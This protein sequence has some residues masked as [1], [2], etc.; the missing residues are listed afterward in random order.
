MCDPEYAHR[1]RW[2]ALFVLCLTLAILGI[3]TS[4]VNVAIPTF[5]K[6]PS[7]GGLGASGSELQWIVDVYVLV[8]AGLLLTAG[9]LGDRFGRV[10]FLNIG[11][12]LFGLSSVL[13]AEASSP[14][15]LIAARATMG[16]G[17]A[18]IMPATLSLI[19]NIFTEPQER[20][21]AIGI[22]AGV[23]AIGVGLG[24]II[25]GVLIEYFW[26]GS[27]FL[28]NIPVVVA[29]LVLGWFFLP[30]SRD[31]SASKL[32]PLGSLLSIGGLI[33]LLWAIIEGPSY[34]WTSTEVVGAF[35]TAFVLLGAFLVWELR[36]PTPMLD[37]H[38]FQ[39]PRFAAASGA[40]TITSMAL[41]GVVFLF[42]Q[43]VQLVLGYSAIEAGAS[44]IPMA[45]LLVMLA[46]RSPRLV[47]RFGTKRVVATGMT[48]AAT[49]FLLMAMLDVDTPLWVVI[50]VTLP[51][52]IG[53][54][55]VFAPCTESIMGSLPREKA[56][57]GS[58]MNDT[59]RQIGGALGVA[60]LGS[61]LSARFTSEISDGLSGVLPARTLAS[62]EDSMGGALDVARA[63]SSGGARIAA[64][65]RES[66]VSGMHLAFVVGAVIM[67]LGVLAALRWLPA[68]PAEAG[69]HASAADVAPMGVTGVDVIPAAAMADVAEELQ[70]LHDH[71]SAPDAPQR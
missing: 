34:G 2:R 5:S 47:A 35:V 11:L 21:K 63:A 71:Q 26:W 69:A 48:F 37:L 33:A 6:P 32:D 68:R 24:P 29:S 23:A 1:Q 3:D 36:Y 64:I 40:I 53:M 66:F 52:G 28:V 50:L 25:G 62:A 42:T 54:S 4:V 10:R 46:P 70:Y 20:A 43:Y 7:A 58:A 17:A 9:S 45:F 18:C 61:I 56:G 65:A 19:T 30:E 57:V 27:V 49:A 14:S 38:F 51:L 8:F 60:I 39:R 12:V 67:L 22:W 16:I 41:F 13:A 55:Q 44:G 59:T 15:V 31:E